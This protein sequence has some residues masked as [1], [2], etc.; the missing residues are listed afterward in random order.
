ME[1]LNKICSSLAK[2]AS[3]IIRS[4]FSISKEM[5]KEI[6][7]QT[8]NFGIFLKE[9]PDAS[10]HE[11]II[12]I[13]ELYSEMATDKS[14]NI[15]KYSRSFVEFSLKQL[16]TRNLSRL[17]EKT[18]NIE[19]CSYIILH[20]C[21]D[22]EL[23][24]QK[25]FY[26]TE[27]CDIGVSKLRS[28]L[29]ILSSSPHTLT[30]PTSLILPF[31]YSLCDSYPPRSSLSRLVLSTFSELNPQIIFSI[32]GGWLISPKTPAL[33]TTI[34]NLLSHSCPQ[35]LLL[36]SSL[37]FEFPVI[38]CI[39]PVSLSSYS[40]LSLIT[41]HRFQT[42]YPSELTTFL[43]LCP[44][45]VRELARR[46][47]IPFPY[48]NK[49][50]SSYVISENSVIQNSEHNSKQNDTTSNLNERAE[51]I[52]NKVEVD[53]RTINALKLYDLSFYPSI[54]NAEVEMPHPPLTM[55]EMTALF[56]VGSCITDYKEKFQHLIP[57]FTRNVLLK[58][59]KNPID[60]NTHYQEMNVD[61]EKIKYIANAIQE[62]KISD[63]RAI[64][65]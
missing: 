51:Q 4:E 61:I 32:V 16:P 49:L 1:D 39:L 11:D 23:F 9:N 46:K 6:A 62:N 42:F 14:S 27:K 43:F 47:R 40:Q 64:L 26:F 41:L 36:I 21:L 15:Y 55:D 56:T 13:F 22:P 8:K 65:Q 58:H 28:F 24:Y 19:L 7:Q 57:S 45:C 30:I 20:T 33:A 44:P 52:P 54:E 37:C 60:R 29:S 50:P 48:R 12:Q 17:W 10:D 38:F 2:L 63:I 3:E 53:D 35:T 25:L 5:T 59:L 34:R 31:T 18:E